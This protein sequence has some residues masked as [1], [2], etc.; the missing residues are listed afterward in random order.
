MNELYPHTT[1]PKLTEVTLDVRSVIWK[2]FELVDR[3]EIA[4]SLYDQTVVEP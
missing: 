3:L 4:N 2:Y 1:F